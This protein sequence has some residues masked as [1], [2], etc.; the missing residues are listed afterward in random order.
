MEQAQAQWER[1]Q[2]YLPI[3]RELAIAILIFIVGW[4]LSKWVNRLTLKALRL[5]KLDEALIR[6]MAGI[7]QYTVLAAA[8]IAALGAVGVETTSLVAVLASAGLAV[9]LALQGS[10]ANFSSGVMILF[11]RPFTIDDRVTVSDHT[12]FVKDIGLFA[13]TLLT[14]DNHTIIVPNSE[15]TSNAVVNYTR[16]GVIRGRVDVGVAYGTQV[17]P[18]IEALLKAARHTE[19]VLKDPEPDIRFDGLGASSL[20][21]QVYAWCDADDLIPMTHHLRT[22]VYNALNEAGF[23]IPFSQIVVHQAG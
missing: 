18:V 8:V 10:L 9:G 7:F 1:L 15:I 5:R 11:F 2:P 4:I 17:A 23:E 16:K 3:L 22:S 20:D 14:L 12:G 6:F 13:T 19:M 21:F